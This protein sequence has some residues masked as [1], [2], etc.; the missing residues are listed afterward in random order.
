MSTLQSQILL[1]E[2]IFSRQQQ[3]NQWER[4][5][6]EVGSRSVAMKKIGSQPRMSMKRSILCLTNIKNRVVKKETQSLIEMKKV[7]LRLL[8]LISILV[9]W[10]KGKYVIE[11][12][13]SEILNSDIKMAINMISL[14]SSQEKNENITCLKFKK[15]HSLIGLSI[16]ILSIPSKKYSVRMTKLKKKNRKFVLQRKRLLKKI[17]MKEN[18]SSQVIQVKEDSLEQSKSS[19]NTYQIHQRLKST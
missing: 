14:R 11:M 12:S 13:C 8:L 10:R 18:H 7:A 3:N 19:Q 5:L 9:Q 16:L 6:K 15:N 4:M 1:Q 17:F 2:E